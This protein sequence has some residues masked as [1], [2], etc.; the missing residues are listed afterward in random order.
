MKKCPKCATK[1]PQENKFCKNC[2][3]PLPEQAEKSKQPVWL[4]TTLTLTIV[5][6]LAVIFFLMGKQNS[7]Q[8]AAN[9]HIK[10]SKVTNKELKAKKQASSSGSSATSTSSKNKIQFDPANMDENT[11]LAAAAYYAG[12]KGLRDWLQPSI[13]QKYPLYASALDEEGGE[14]DEGSH[15]IMINGKGLGA[16]SFAFLTTD[17]DKVYFYRNGGTAG[18][19]EDNSTPLDSTTWSAIADYVNSRD[20]YQ[21][22]MNIAEN[23]EVND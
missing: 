21:T 12:S 18:S 4:I 1:N 6:L 23:A 13:Y 16:G 8:D 19:D 10:T 2:G 11:R 9:S 5:V 22:I 7:T 17:G 3:A 20:A 15:P 14:Y